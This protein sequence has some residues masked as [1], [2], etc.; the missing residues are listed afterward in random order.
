MY[1][2][3]KK[4][5]VVPNKNYFNFKENVYIS[6]VVIFSIQAGKKLIR[7]KKF[8]YFDHFSLFI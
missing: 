4:N 6:E 5:N 7:D 8:A 2:S 1:F 3:R